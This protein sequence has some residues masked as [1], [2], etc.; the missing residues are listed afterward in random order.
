M[1]T[2]LA[3]SVDATD[4]VL[5]LREAL[6]ESAQ[7]ASHDNIRFDPALTAAGPATIFTNGDMLT[8]ASSVSVI[9]PGADL[10]TIDAG[11]GEDGLFA[12]G[13][14]DPVIYIYDGTEPALVDVDISGLTITGGDANRNLSNAGGGVNNRE[15]LT[16]REVH[17]VRNAAHGGGGLHS[18]GNV[19]LLD[20]TISGNVAIAVGGGIQHL[21]RHGEHGSLHV[22]NSTISGNRVEGTTTTTRA[23]GG[24]HSFGNLIVENSTITQNSSEDIGGGI[25]SAG[26]P[27]DSNDVVSIR[28][29]I[30]SGNTATEFLNLHDIRNE[31]EF[32]SGASRFVG[33][34]NLTGVGFA[35]IGANNLVVDDPLIGSLADN[36]G[37]TP[38]HSVLPNSPAVDAGDPA[39][40]GTSIP[41]DQRGTGF[42]RVSDGDGDGNSIVDIGA[43]EFTPRPNI[44][45]TFTMGADQSVPEDIGL[46]QVAGF[47]T[48]DPGDSSESHQNVLE[49]VLDTQNEQLF[50]TL[51]SINTAGS[52]TFTPAN[53]AFGSTTVSVFVRDDGGTGNGGIDTS[54][55]QLLTISINPVNDAPTFSL[56]ALPRV[57]GGAGSQVIE[58]FISSTSPGPVNESEQSII[59]FTV[60]VVNHSVTPADFFETMPDIDGQGNLSYSVRDDILSG[61][62]TL[63]INIQDDGGT[64]NGGVDVSDI[65][66][67]TLEVVGAD[68][69]DAPESFPVTRNQDGAHH[70]SGTLRLG[71][72]IDSEFDGVISLSASDDDGDDGVMTIAS[73]LGVAGVATTSSFE[74]IASESGRLDAWI[75]FTAD[76]DW[77][78]A[79]EQIADSFVLDAGSNTLSFTV[80]ETAVAGN[81]VARFRIS[82]AGSL[83]PTGLAVDGEV[84]D[85]IVDVLDGTIRPQVVVDVIDRETSIFTRD[86][87]IVVSDTTT[88][89]F[90][91][92]ITD[93]ESMQILGTL[94]DDIFT[95]DMRALSPTGQLFLDGSDGFNTLKVTGSDG[96]LDLTSID[97]ISL[98]NVS[99]IDLT[100]NTHNAIIANAAV[101]DALASETEFLRITGRDGDAIELVNPGNWRMG[102][103]V[104]DEGVFYRSVV[105]ESGANERINLDLPRPWQNNIR[106]SD[107]NNNGNVSVV[108]ALTIINE[109][110]RKRFLFISTNEL[111][112]PLNVREFPDLYVDQNGDD[113]LTPLDAL[114]VINEIARSRVR[115]LREGESTNF[116]HLIAKTSDDRKLGNDSDALLESVATEELTKTRIPQ[117]GRSDRRNDKKS[118][119]LSEIQFESELAEIDRLITEFDF[120]DS[121]NLASN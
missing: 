44:Q 41:F 15:E 114:G 25:S 72:Q 85:Y 97:V 18:S 2:T 45:P 62:A 67:V 14:G 113:H 96:N 69:G 22:H 35:V 63:E 83:L 6:A 86:S 46:V 109:L 80:P 49:Y 29:S 107:V 108:D 11:N 38:T 56:R 24:I 3:D 32:A 57:T 12:T 54:E 88:D 20:S 7:N 104:I 116:D 118:I 27:S 23:G 68:F 66:S 21:Q 60:N 10:L 77:N 93:V 87:A 58:K 30:V 102:P 36:G 81:P 111:F 52:L 90:A 59:A 61:T 42:P 16:L 33:D 94:S 91:A 34:H 120:I 70:I 101:A 9:G 95:L 106:P 4:G 121:S 105:H 13:D 73:L 74:I 115:G 76:G 1:V 98:A 112:D 40:N 99:L 65:E 82:S 47:A 50:Q 89:L 5:S 8:I 92:P 100:G 39:I 103:T 28:N 64:E 31:D 117:A 43:F 75:D 84:E 53:N 26:V 78:D 51:P 79:G 71:S 37:P 48:F 119:A 19:T 17:I 55:T 110:A